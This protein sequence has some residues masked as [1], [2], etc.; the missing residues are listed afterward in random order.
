MAET[1]TTTRRRAAKPKAKPTG[2][3]LRAISHGVEFV[4]LYDG[5]RYYVGDRSFTSLSSAA[6]YVRGK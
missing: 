4:C 5:K 1:K 6:D 2:K 3:E